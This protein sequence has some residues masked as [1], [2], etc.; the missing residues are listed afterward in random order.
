MSNEEDRTSSKPAVH[1]QYL[2]S[3]PSTL[4]KVS[5]LVTFCQFQGFKNQPK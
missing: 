3:F 4:L 2:T 1:T 5:V